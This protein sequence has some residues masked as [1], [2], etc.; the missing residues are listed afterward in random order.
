MV[1]NRTLLR[2]LPA[3]AAIALLYAAPAVAQW[4]KYP[5]PGIPRTPDGK[6]NLSAPT[7]KMTDGHPDLSGVWH[8]LAGQN[9]QPRDAV[10]TPYPIFAFMPKGATVP[11]QPWAEDLWKKRVANGGVDRP[12][13]KCLPH[14][15]PDA[16]IYG[17]PMKLVE[18]PTLL[19]ILFDEQTRFRQVFTDGRGDAPEPILPAWYGYSSG[20]WEGD[21]LV[22]KTRGFREGSWLDD[23][24]LTHTDAL[25]VTER[26]TR[27]DLGHMDAHIT[28]DDPKAYTAPFSI[29]LKFELMTNDELIES[30]CEE[31][32]ADN[33]HISNLPK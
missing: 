25:T 27:H 14:G 1:N 12:A 23:S 9:Q 15:V 6:A 8:H 22:V 16:M 21:T 4:M 10:G 5:N 18:T 2:H 30:L 28:M 32:E 11:F 24:G 17:G 33:A 13:I 26:F 3:I 29:D 19:V 7:P 20:K 31:N